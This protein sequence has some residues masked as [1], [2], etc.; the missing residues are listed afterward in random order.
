[1]ARVNGDFAGTMT[2]CKDC[3]WPLVMTFLF[4][5]KEWFCTKCH[6]IDEFFGYGVET[7][8]LTA[9]LEKQHNTA[10]RQFKKWVEE[11]EKVQADAK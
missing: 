3:R 1:M 2:I 7:V 11:R 8:R 9:Q 5:G 6:R 10:R 4:P